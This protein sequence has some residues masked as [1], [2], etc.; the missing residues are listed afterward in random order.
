MSRT[1]RHYHPLLTSD[2]RTRKNTGDIDRDRYYNGY[3]GSTSD[4]HAPSSAGPKG[5][6]TYN[7]VGSGTK[8]WAKRAA[9]KVVRRRAID[10]INEIINEADDNG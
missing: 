5:Y 2:A 4:C 1:R 6:D 7:E 10:D 8:K 9:A 3:D